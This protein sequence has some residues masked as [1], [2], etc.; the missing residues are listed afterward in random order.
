M[1]KKPSYLW[2]LATGLGFPILQVLI[3]LLRFGSLN[4]DSPVTDTIFFFIAGALIGLVLIAA[5]RRCE[6]VGAYRA[7]LVGFAIGIPFV[8]FGMVMGGLMGPL[9]SIFLGVSPG[10]FFI[11]IGYFIGRVFFRK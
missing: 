1:D 8:L 2:A 10:V 6:S 7:T 11:A 3:F 5:L 9:G 4:T